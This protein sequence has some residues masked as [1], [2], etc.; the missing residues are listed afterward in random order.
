MAKKL[1]SLV[2]GFVGS[3]SSESGNNP[4]KNEPVESKTKV[5]TAPVASSS[6]KTSTTLRINEDLL[7]KL[8]YIS[9]IEGCRLNDVY[10]AA[11]NDY[12]NDWEKQNGGINIK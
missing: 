12:V 8:K 10:L 2:S 4:A 5:S 7:R 6:S 1:Q 3:Q 11:L 9:I